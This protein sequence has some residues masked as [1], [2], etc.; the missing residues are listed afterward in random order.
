MF[1]A[2]ISANHLAQKE[3]Q[4]KYMEEQQPLSAFG[5]RL[6]AMPEGQ[7]R[8][9]RKGLRRLG[10]H[11]VNISKYRHKG[12]NNLTLK[13]GYEVSVIMGCAVSEL[14]DDEPTHKT[15]ATP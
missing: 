8:R 15:R 12:I 3:T 9:V 1:A 2:S 6:A 13:R 11:P 10:I 14:L 7:A 4:A 5:R